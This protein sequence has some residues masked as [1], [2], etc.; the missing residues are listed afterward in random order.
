MAINIKKGLEQVLYDSAIEYA[1]QAGQLLKERLGNKG[2]IQQKKNISD[3]VT[4]VDQLSE[5][6]LRG[7]IQEDYPDHWI[8][9]EED[10]G[11]A[12][13]YEVF[14]NQDSGYGWIIDPIDGTTN[15]IHGIPHFSVSI[16]VV[17]AGK[18]VIGVVFN[19]I[20]G[21]LYAARKSFGAYLNGRP[22]RVGKESTLAEAV[23]ATGFQA[24]DFKSGSRVIQQ[25][26]KLAG[27]SRSIRIFGA[28]SLDLCL[29]ASGK[30]TGFW[31]EGLN[32][33]DTAAGVLILTEAG[34]QVTDQDGN[35]YCLFHD[36]L[37]A[38][39]GKIHDELMKTIKL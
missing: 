8:L 33:W 15:F 7:K 14:K 28:A 13:A 11:Q 25:M 4:E 12:N 5:E 19:P 26:D 17:K 27:K 34:G 36:S 21:E 32:P 39:N 6:L 9:S 3:L 22:I 29:V 10:C 30:I 37:I 1:L 16:G 20:T 23:V 24:S 38:S 18:P 35:P 2:K 31:H